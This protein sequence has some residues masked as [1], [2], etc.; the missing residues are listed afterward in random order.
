[1][2]LTVLGSGTSHGVPMIGCDCPVCTSPDPRNRRT[3]CSA[4][5]TVNGA[6]LLIDTA[7]E[8]RLQ[9]V[10]NGI[11]RIDA[12]L[13]TH[14]HADHVSGIDDLKSF[15]HVKGGTLTCFG[16]DATG[17]WLKLRYDFAFAGTQ[18]LGAIPDLRFETVDDEPFKAAG[19][20]VTPIPLQHGRIRTTG[21]RIG[22][23]AY[24][25]DTNGV[26]ESSMRALRGLEVLVLD[27]LRHRPHPTHFNIVQALEVVEQLRPSQTYLTHLT[28]EVD[29][30][31]VNAVL[32][33]GVELAYDG[34]TVEL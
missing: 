27:G 20:E 25:T 24:L 2:R 5:V 8:L 1:M 23:I 7:T 3:R 4:Y 14:Y 16:D 18:W 15:N 31:S 28:H 29:H 6:H 9:A 11:K 13:Y 22:D 32:P 19:V 34:L 33:S 10:T 21:Y 26:P 12:I 30:A 17:Y